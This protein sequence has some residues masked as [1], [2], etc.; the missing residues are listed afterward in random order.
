VIGTIVTKDYLPFARVLARSLR[1]HHPECQLVVALADEID[2]SFEPATEPFSI[3]TPA[4]LQVPEL[5]D[6]AFRTTQ[7]AFP[8]ALKPYLLARLLDQSDSALF[9]DPDVLVLGNLD[10][11]FDRVQHQALTLVPHAL[12]PSVGPDRLDRELV[13][14][15]AGVF[16]AG[17]VGVRRGHSTAGFLSWWQRRVHN[18]CVYAVDRGVH[19]DQRWLD[20]ALGFVEDLHVHRDVGVDVAHWNLPERPIRIRDGVVTA[21]GA[22]CRLFHFSGFDPDH[23]E[24]PTRY[25]PSL[26][27]EELGEAQQLFGDYADELRRAGWEDAR[28]LPY[29]YGSFHNGVPIPD[30][31]RQLFAQLPDRSKWGDPF[32]ASETQ[33]YF[34]WLH[35]SP[36]RFR[37]A[38]GP[39]RL[40]LFV[41]G[42]RPDLQRAFPHPLGIDRRRFLNWTREHGSRE[43]AVPPELG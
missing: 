12:E 10:S 9:L 23:P 30:I 13:L 40:W 32:A 24:L 1:R 19:Y 2:G 8:I 6:L 28:D 29:A 33:S 31:A 3:L 26:R 20:L 25:R 17:V 7:R 15:R 35:E 41:H 27:F 21:A 38:R 22:P 18:L 36:A 39:N 14:H 11:L 4:E 16:N 42:Q 34:R 43:H 5:R 37:P